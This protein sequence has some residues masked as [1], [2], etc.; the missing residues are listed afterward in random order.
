MKKL[1]ILTREKV[2][3]RDHNKCVRC[4][5]DGSQYQMHPSHVIGR[6]NKR[7]RWDINNVKTMCF[8]CHRWWHDNPTESGEWFKQKYPERHEYIEA[9]KNEIQKT[10]L[11]VLEE[12][13]EATR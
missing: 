5:R 2:F 6:Q 11:P 10:T 13:Y 1:D 8:I 12:L 9:H 7:L 4:G 3:E